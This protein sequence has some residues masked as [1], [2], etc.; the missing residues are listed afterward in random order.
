MKYTTVWCNA[1]TKTVVVQHS[2]LYEWRE[3][4]VTWC[5]MHTFTYFKRVSMR[6]IYRLP[7]AVTS[8]KTS[9]K[10]RRS[11]TRSCTRPNRAANQWHRLRIRSWCETLPLRFFGNW[12]NSLGSRKN[13]NRYSRCTSRTRNGWLRG[14][15]PG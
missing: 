5:R 1:I 11:C 10:R 7:F 3:H 4:R 2:F 13:W 12:F 6:V 14:L 15:F 9:L 8:L